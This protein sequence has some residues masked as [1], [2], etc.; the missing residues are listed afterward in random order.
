MAE[1][2]LSK[3]YEL[4]NSSK[5]TTKDKKFLNLRQLNKQNIFDPGCE[6]KFAIA[7]RNNLIVR[8]EWSL[9]KNTCSTQIYWYPWKQTLEDFFNRRLKKVL[10]LSIKVERKNKLNMIISNQEYEKE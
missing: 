7:G 2:F 1:F 5:Y 3:G 8:F 9:V 4:V 10:I 6:P